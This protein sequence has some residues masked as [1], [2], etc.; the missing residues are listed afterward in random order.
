MSGR[1]LENCAKSTFEVDLNEV[2]CFNGGRGLA[3]GW[4]RQ[5]AG[6]LSQTEQATMA[7]NPNGA[8]AKDDSPSG[9]RD[10]KESREAPSRWPHRFNE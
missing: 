4:A 9:E 8:P 1:A 6:E 7:S 10:L 3:T 5:Q 2:G